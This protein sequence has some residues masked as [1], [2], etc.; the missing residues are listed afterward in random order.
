[1]LA[2]LALSACL[3]GWLAEDS[4]RVPDVSQPDRA[5]YE[6]AKAK[7]GRSAEEHV[8]LA[9][10]CEAHGM[11]AERVKHLTLAILNDPKQAT[12]R[13]LLGMVQYNGKWLRPEAVS[14]A[15][16]ADEALN[17]ALAEYNARRAKTPETADA[18]G[19]LA[20][21]CESKGL[22]AEAAAHYT[23]VTRLE[24]NNDAAWR[25]LGYR[26]DG[27]R[28]VL[29]GQVAA[30][31]AEFEAQKKADKAWFKSLTK[32]RAELNNPKRRAEAEKNL[33]S[34]SDPRA[35]PAIWVVFGNGNEADQRQ[36]LRLL[37]QMETA[38]SS[39][40][41]AM[42]SVFS[43]FADIR[44]RAVE[45][46][47]PRDPRDYIHWMISLLRD[48]LKYEVKPVDGP[49]STGILVVEGEQ[50]NLR[51]TYTPPPLPNI[52]IFDGEKITYDADG[53]PM[54]SRTVPPGRQ[55]NVSFDPNDDSGPNGSLEIARAPFSRSPLLPQT[56]V[57]VPVG[58]ILL[59]H[60]KAA[61]AS[62]ADLESDIAKIDRE[63]AMIR[64]QNDRVSQI[65]RSVTG[66]DEGKKRDGWKAWAT[67]R[68]GYAYKSTPK[69]QKPTIDQNIPSSY[70]I[71][72]GISISATGLVTQVVR[73]TTSHSCFKVGTLVN[74]LAG[75]KAIETIQ[76]GDEV[77]TQNTVSGVL[78]YQPV[79]TVFHNPPTMTYKVDLGTETVSATGIHRFW[80]AGQGW[81]MARDL[82]PG[83]KIRTLQGVAEV[84]SVSEETVVPVFNLEVASGQSFFVGEAGA[85]VHDNSLVQPVFQAF[86]RGTEMTPA[87]RTA[88][89]K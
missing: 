34:V 35:V 42:L 27:N 57:E 67:D 22:K 51:R 59:E 25:H 5:A 15:V 75:G 76:V 38:S 37:G 60:Q 41:L 78:S 86:D 43:D 24:P 17:Q 1:M 29:E 30:E 85:L 68:Q 39:Q 44:K 62:A 82:K 13:G 14:A 31:K 79:L 56:N 53:L 83:D 74:T 55:L 81:V 70:V 11:T 4:S 10:W 84:K 20:L 64:E 23:A 46:L 32:W 66:H 45:T 3:V 50:F 87:T 12:A 33:E 19:K 9:L 63:N 65:L 61:K 47:K 48:E 80:K 26:K 8:K 89:V 72:D 16:K 88:S 36:A 52:K 18:Q 73:A 69:P 54:V 58:R 40:A 49:G 7:V 6:A 77:L 21:W 28:W 2:T 71:P